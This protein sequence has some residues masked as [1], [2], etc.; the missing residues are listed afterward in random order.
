M[1]DHIHLFAAFGPD[2]ISLSA[3]I[4][5]MKSAL[6]AEF[7]KSAL[8]PPSWQK[9]L[10]DHLL[11]SAESYEQKWEYV[12]DNPVRAGLVAKHVDWPYQG[13]IHPLILGQL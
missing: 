7:R 8:L 6:S 12:R 2:S 11:R 5:A 4:K 13:E 3:W 1:P 9:G 10:F